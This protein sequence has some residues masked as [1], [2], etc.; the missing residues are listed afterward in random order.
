MPGKMAGI[1]TIRVLVVEDNR[2]DAELLKKILEGRTEAQ[3]VVE[4]ARTCAEA[5]ARLRSNGI[6]V[7]LLDLGLPDAHG[8]D[9]VRR[10]LEAGPKVRIMAL[11]GRSDPET[12]ERVKEAGAAEYL[13]KPAEPSEISR[14]IQALVIRRQFEEERHEI[15]DVLEEVGTIFLRANEIQRRA[16]AV[17]AAE[18]V[19]KATAPDPEPCD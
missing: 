18:A 3:Y 13:V 12:V 4:L 14:K 9:V 1:R 7:V 10:T 6:E 2:D 15:E 16:E 5:T 8:A 11:T 17:K 19:K